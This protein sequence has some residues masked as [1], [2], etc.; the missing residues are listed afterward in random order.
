MM[1]VNEVSKLTG[2]SIRTLQYYDR[3]GLLNPAGRTEAGYRLY[4][5]AALERLQQILLF[6]ELEFPLKDIRKILQ[7]PSFDRIMA[8]ER[9]ITLLTMKKQHLEDLISLARKIKTTGG[10]CM[11]FTAF[12]TRKIQE[13]EEQAKKEWG[14]TSEYKEFEKKNAGKTMSEVKA[15][16]NQLMD[17]VAEFGALQ[18][19]DPTDPEVQLQVKKLQDFI[20]EHYYTCSKVIL[21]RLGQMYGAGG[22]F[23]ENINAAGGPGTAEFAQ[24]AIEVYREE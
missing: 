6:R 9:Q 5:D 22:A 20:T 18:T 10:N 16:G 1:T 23:T 2:V 13:Y 21:N 7:S 19:R 4:D 3:I 24:R 17:I 8:L 11:E 15:M 14:A 12:D